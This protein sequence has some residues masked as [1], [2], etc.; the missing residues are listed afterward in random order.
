[1]S[2]SPSI[3]NEEVNTGTANVSTVAPQ[4]EKSY[5]KLRR[6][7]LVLTIVLIVVILISLLYLNGK[8]LYEH[9]L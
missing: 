6:A 3:Q 1:M 4:P 8:S 5:V 7:A 9:G 2:D